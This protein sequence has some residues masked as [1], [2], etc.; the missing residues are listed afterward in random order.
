MTDWHQKLLDLKFQQEKKTD[1]S[2]SYVLMTNHRRNTYWTKITVKRVGT[3]TP[4]AWQ[5]TC[6][7]S[8]IQVGLWKIHDT[9][10]DI[11][12][13]VHTSAEKMI[14]DIIYQKSLKPSFWSKISN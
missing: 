11:S 12:V 10:Q 4:D 1:G 5:V 6:A 13:V 3:P 2:S 7:R 9:I 14:E 8:E